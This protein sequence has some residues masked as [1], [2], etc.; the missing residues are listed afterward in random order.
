MSPIRSNATNSIILLG[1]LPTCLPR[2]SEVPK[3][4]E[5]YKGT[6]GYTYTNGRYPHLSIWNPLDSYEIRSHGC[7]HRL[8]IERTCESCKLA[9][10]RKPIGVS[11]IIRDYARHRKEDVLDK[12]DTA[13]RRHYKEV[14][15]SEEIYIDR[16]VFY[17]PR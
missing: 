13:R 5:I 4:I 15:F 17:V 6:L 8:I 7:S 1:T 16:E 9:I 11:I 12:Y 14:I 2:V 3:D 10:F